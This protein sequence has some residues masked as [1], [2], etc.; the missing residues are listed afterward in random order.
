MPGPLEIPWNAGGEPYAPV[1]AELA[2]RKGEKIGA[3]IGRLL[4][5]EPVRLGAT[6]GASCYMCE[7]R[8]ARLNKEYR[9]SN[10]YIPPA[11]RTLLGRRRRDG[12]SL[13]S[14][15]LVREGRSRHY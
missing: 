15:L 13:I 7:C 2:S 9:N 4:V 5:A 11:D 10:T 12:S 14:L 3:T 1:E 6:T 8:L